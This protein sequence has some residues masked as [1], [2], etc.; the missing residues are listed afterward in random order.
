MRE[1]DRESPAGTR[2]TRL[3]AFV[4]HGSN[5]CT[6]FSV[7]FLERSSNDKKIAWYGCKWIAVISWLVVSSILENP[8]KSGAVFCP[9]PSRTRSNVCV[10][11]SLDQTR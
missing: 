7:A 4:S 11:Y 2:V 10:L 6:L 9:M 5:R 3:V 1:R 8:K